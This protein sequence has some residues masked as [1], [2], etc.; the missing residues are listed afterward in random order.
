M[1]LGGDWTV[2]IDFFTSYSSGRISRPYFSMITRGFGYKQLER[3]LAANWKHCVIDVTRAV[4]IVHITF[5]SSMHHH[6]APFTK[7][8]APN[9][10]MTK[11]VYVV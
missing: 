10:A 3:S 6:I 8:S 1:V 2:L 5:N 7:S 11:K 4:S 9:D